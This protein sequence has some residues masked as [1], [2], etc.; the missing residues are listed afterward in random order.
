MNNNTF[1]IESFISFC[2][3]MYIVEESVFSTIKSKIIKLFTS[4]VLFLDKKVKKMKD[5]KL[6]KVL[7]NLLDRAKRGLNISK[8][9]KEEDTEQAQELQ[10]EANEIKMRTNRV[11]MKEKMKEDTTNSN[12]SDTNSN[13]DK[14]HYQEDGK[15]ILG[16]MKPNGETIFYQR[17]GKTIDWIE[18]ANGETIFY[19]E[20]GKTIDYIDEPDDE[21][22]KLFD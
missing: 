14:I 16:I 19:R 17:D 13:G 15:T 22:L 9:M 7:Q 1:A 18:K 6:K 5:T 20:D 3:D 12:Q 11:D 2:D 10:R 21:W 8:N 4:L